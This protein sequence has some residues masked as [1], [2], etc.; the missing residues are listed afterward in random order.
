MDDEKS[1]K[2]ENEMILF[3]ANIMHIRNDMKHL[4]LA[5]KMGKEMEMRKLQQQMTLLRTKQQQREEKVEELQVEA[6]KV[7]GIIQPVHQ[8]VHEVV[9]SIEKVLSK[10]VY[11]DLVEK[12]Y[13]I[14][15]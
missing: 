11:S 7:T 8:K 6:E 12:M 9:A 3:E 5:K 4:P 10:H 1:Q 15:E 13:K 2:I 14:E